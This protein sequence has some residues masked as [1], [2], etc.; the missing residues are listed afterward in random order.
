[1]QVNGSL[2]NNYHYEKGTQTVMCKDV[3]TLE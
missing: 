3:T 1:M 2:Y